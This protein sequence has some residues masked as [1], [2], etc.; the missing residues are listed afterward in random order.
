MAVVSLWVCPSVCPVPDPKSKMEAHRK[1][2]IGEK[3]SR[4][5]GDK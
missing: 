4:D 1:L 2:K 3:E 5:T